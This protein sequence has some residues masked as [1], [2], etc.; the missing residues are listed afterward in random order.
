[1]RYELVAR[2]E[3]VTLPG[4]MPFDGYTLNGTTPRRPIRAREG[5]LE[6]V[7]RNENVAAGT[8]LH[9]HGLDVP[10]GMDGV[11]GVTQ[12]AVLPGES[13]TYRFVAN[14]VGHVLVPLAPGR[15][16]AGRGRAVRCPRRRAGGRGRAGR[17]RPSPIPTP[18]R[19][20]GLSGVLGDAHREAPAGSRV[21]MRSSTPT[22][23]RLP[24]G[25]PAAPSGWWRSTGSTSTG[26]PRSRKGRRVIVPAGGRVDLAV[27]VPASGGVRLQAPGVSLVLGPAGASAADGVQPG[28]DP[29]PAGPTERRFHLKVRDRRVP[30]RRFSYDIG[31]LPGFLDGRP[32]FWWSINGRFVPHVPMFVVAEGDVVA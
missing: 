2:A 9:W 17:R 12:D 11:A 8:T 22:T 19:R 27:E 29:R 3:R 4:A 21:R 16:P 32:G 26:R 20:A 13:F 1:M 6:V 25:S 14:Q 23:W 24:C 31:R 28:G 5:V 15:Q 30:D 10:N 18:A 7:L